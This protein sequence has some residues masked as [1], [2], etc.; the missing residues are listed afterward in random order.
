MN[1]GMLA[2]T[3]PLGRLV[4]LPLKLMP[5]GIVVPI[6]TGPLWGKK[7]IVGTGPHG[8]WIGNWERDKQRMVQRFLRHGDS[9]F[10]VGANLGFYS[11]LASRLVGATGKVI[12]FE[13]LSRNVQTLKAHMRMNRARNVTV[14]EAAVSD[15]EGWACFREGCDDLSGKLTE[16]GEGVVRTVALDALWRNGQVPTPRVIKIDVEGAEGAV[17]RGARNLLAS[18]NPILLLSG[19]GSPV[20]RE[21]ERLLDELGYKVILQRDGSPDGMGD[22]MYEAVAL[23][24]CRPG[25]SV[26]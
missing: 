13:P 23:P 6:L 9:F 12:A 24:V 18:A 5:H 21:C 19:H 4:R 20:Q 10:D 17:L 15:S 25:E 11:L 14:W 1:D 22:G 3:T 26:P 16:G 7:W 2:N 8:F